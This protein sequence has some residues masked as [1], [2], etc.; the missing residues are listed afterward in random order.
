MLVLAGTKELLRAVVGH[1]VRVLIAVEPRGL[2]HRARS[3]AASA[4]ALAGL[5]RREAQESERWI[6]AISTGDTPQPTDSPLREAR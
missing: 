3:N 6:S 2:H 4:A 5:H 1:A